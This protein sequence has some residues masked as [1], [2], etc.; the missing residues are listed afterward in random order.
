M[1]E[2]TIAVVFGILG[3]VV[4]LLVDLIKSYQ[5]KKK[6]D[7]KKFGFYAIL[8]IASGAFS[9]ILFGFAKQ[10]SFLGGYA[11]MDLIDGYYKH[12]TRKKFKIRFDIEKN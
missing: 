2:L 3:G 7:S 5:S 4:R 8:V 12:F 6:I 10:L 1:S 9:G 11:G